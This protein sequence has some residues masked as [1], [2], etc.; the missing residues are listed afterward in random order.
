MREGMKITQMKWYP[1]AAWFLP[2][3]CFMIMYVARVVPGTFLNELMTSFDVSHGAVGVLGSA[4]LQG[5]VLMQLPV[6]LLVDRFGPV[7]LLLIA[8][9]LGIFGNNMFE[10]SN[11]LSQAYVA[12]LLLGMGSAFIFVCAFKQAK[13]WLSA[14]HFPF[15]CGLTQVFGMLGAA[16]GNGWMHSSDISWRVTLHTITQIWCV[17]LVVMLMVLRS[18]RD[19]SPKAKHSHNVKEMFSGLMQVLGNSNSWLNGLYA[20]LVFLP[21][22]VL[23]GWWGPYYLSLVHDITEAQAGGLIGSIFI[24]WAIGGSVIGYIAGRWKCT[25]PLMILS[26]MMSL[27][28]LSLGLYVRIC[29]MFV[30]NIIFFLYGVCNAGLI[31]AYALSTELVGIEVAGSAIAF[32]NVM[33]IILGV[34]LQPGIGHGVSYITAYLGEKIAFDIVMLVLPL[35]LIVSALMAYRLRLP[36]GHH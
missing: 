4:F 28:F 35:G 10:V 3:L 21:T 15:A 34:I 1:W 19:D 27:V 12:R 5:Y 24:G 25:K 36:K 8:S 26:A 14:R 2:A 11:T 31:L 22:E 32:T 18:K 20:G 6:G 29:P 13:I 9:V 30:L 17:L 7:T 16:I 23:G 33:S